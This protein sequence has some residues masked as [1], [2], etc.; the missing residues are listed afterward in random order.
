[1]EQPENTGN[2]GFNQAPKRQIKPDEQLLID[3]FTVLSGKYGNDFPKIVEYVQKGML[4]S[5]NQSM[6]VSESVVVVSDLIIIPAG[7]LVSI[8]FLVILI[9]YF[10]R[11]CCALFNNYSIRLYI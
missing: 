3:E 11:Y 7:F 1:M 8:F 6:S 9:L 10:E 4:L 2:A 5:V